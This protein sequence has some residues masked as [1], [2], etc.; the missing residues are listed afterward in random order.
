MQS[1][2]SGKTVVTDGLQLGPQFS[3]FSEQTDVFLTTAKNA[4]HNNK[5]YM[6]GSRVLIDSFMSIF[7]DMDDETARLVEE[8][9]KR[10]KAERTTVDSGKFISLENS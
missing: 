1:L 6:E 7:V 2:G 4:R 9:R 8:R 3:E 10:R 5:K